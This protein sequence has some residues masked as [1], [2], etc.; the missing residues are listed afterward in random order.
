MLYLLPGMGA[1]SAMYDGP[2]RD[3]P[4]S[5]AVDWPDYQGEKTIAQVAAR[6]IAEHNIGPN[7]SIVGSSLGGL[8]ALEIHAEVGLR[9]VILIGSATSSQEINPLLIALA[10]LAKLTP[11]RLIQHLAGKS[12]SRLSTMYA[13]VDAEFVRA[14]CGAIANWGGYDGSM[15][16]VTRLHGDR[17]HVIRRPA[18]THIIPGG[19]HLITITHAEE[20]IAIINRPIH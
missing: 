9:R 10:P 7:D 6:L 15:Q 19:G 2:W 12:A 11:M 3:M 20:C 16:A 18:D 14:M 4:D 13:Q 1:T 8:V 5:I 17:D